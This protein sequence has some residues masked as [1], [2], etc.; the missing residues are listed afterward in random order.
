[1][2]V[3]PGTERALAFVTFLFF[4]VAAHAESE[5]A[6]VVGDSISPISLEDQHGEIGA[7][8]DSTRVVLFSRDMD[9]GKLLQAALT[10]VEASFL[11]ESHVVYV[12][13]ISGMPSLVARLFALP[14]MRKRPYR[15]LLDRTGD[16]TSRLPD[17]DAKATLIFLQSLR[18][19][20][21]EHVD[22][23]EKIRA[24]LGLPPIPEEDD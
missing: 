10:D 11:D 18:I 22:D 7:V 21:V 3:N 15:M 2:R 8:D 13:D 1:M 9:G 16:A 19:E 5:T 12:S 4:S 23:T 24:S 6:Y 17:V 20:R 14:K